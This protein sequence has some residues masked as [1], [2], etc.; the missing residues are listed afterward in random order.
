MSEPVTALGGAVFETGIATV[1]EE[2]VQGMITLRG[3][4][5]DSAVRAAAIGASGAEMPDRGTIT[6]S[7][8]ASLAWMSP[9]ELMLLCP[10]GEVPE[11]LAR[12]QEGLGD[13]HALAVNVSDARALLSVVG[14]KARDVLAKL[15][16]VDLSPGAFT[17]GMFRRT[18]MAQVGAAF[19]MP[20]EETFRV[21]C[22]R[23][24]TQYV[25]DVL[26]VAAQKGSDVGIWPDPTGGG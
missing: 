26:T 7:E 24:Q 1:R 3:D 23:S 25:F 5:E 19:W 22:F 9:D 20:T 4:L 14:P 18:R 2:P 10:H 21:V 6:T 8:D 13:A 17:P 15:C 16:P 11:R 12:L